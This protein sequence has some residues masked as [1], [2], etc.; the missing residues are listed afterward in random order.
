MEEP[1]Q[2]SMKIE[3][4]EEIEGR[5]HNEDNFPKLPNMSE[6]IGQCNAAE[7]KDIATLKDNPKVELTSNLAYIGSTGNLV[8]SVQYYETVST[9]PWLQL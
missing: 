2:R 4:C 8:E 9:H 1:M 5:Y 6:N 3:T 7:K